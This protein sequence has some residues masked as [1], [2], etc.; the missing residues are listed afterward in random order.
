MA[1]DA[2]PA[3]LAQII[4]LSTSNQLNVKSGYS[5][6]DATVFSD[7][8]DPSKVL[9]LQLSGLT[10]ATTRT[11]TF[12]DRDVTLGGGAGSRASVLGSSG[13]LTLTAAMSGSTMLFDVAGATAYALPAVAAVDVGTTFRFWTTVTATGNHTITAAAADLLIGTA[14]MAVTAADFEV[15]HPNGSSH[16]VITQ[17]GTTS[18]GVE[19]SFVEVVALSATRWGVQA[20]L[21]CTGVQITPFS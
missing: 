18:G 19:G 7:S 4:E 2:T 1:R 14:S 10:A 5:I 13:N 8:A 16:L 3:E 9:A 20:M 11:L 12:P 15:F 17:N 6:S 21:N